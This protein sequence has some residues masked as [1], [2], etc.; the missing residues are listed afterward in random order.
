[1]K[2]LLMK[3]ILT[4]V[5][6]LMF[7]TVLCVPFAYCASTNITSKLQSK[8]NPDNTLTGNP[9]LG[10]GDNSG[11]GAFGGSGGTD[12]MNVPTGGSNPGNSPGT[13]LFGTFPKTG[14]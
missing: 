3:K 10:G 1:M 11:G 8:S 2:E 6:A 4:L 5:I 13:K 7:I 12:G 14:D 9:T